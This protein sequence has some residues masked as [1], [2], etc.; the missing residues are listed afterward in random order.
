[1]VGFFYIL[2]V[3]K[4]NKAIILII[5]RFD[6]FIVFCLFTSKARKLRIND[7][8]LKW[9]LNH[10]SNWK[11][12][13]L[14]PNS[15]NLMNTATP[16]VKA[17]HPVRS[18]KWNDRR[19]RSVLWWEITREHRVSYSF[20]FAIFFHFGITFKVILKFFIF[21]AFLVSPF[22]LTLNEKWA[23][24]KKQISLFI[25]FYFIHN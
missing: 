19:A 13:E 2:F 10:L 14:K 16:R 18:V 24:V 5:F 15:F 21:F 6:L 11:L 12:V 22:F 1:M 8:R 20:F 3:F 17:P 7:F 9:E 4:L 25:L 23:F